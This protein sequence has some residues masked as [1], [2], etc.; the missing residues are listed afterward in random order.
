MNT[1]ER[2]QEAKKHRNVRF[3]LLNQKYYWMYRAAETAEDVLRVN[4][5]Y[6]AEAHE[7]TEQYVQEVCAAYRK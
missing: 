3:D 6:K 2:V 4:A 5:W 7:I 1:F